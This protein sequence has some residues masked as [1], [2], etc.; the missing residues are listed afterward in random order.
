[1]SRP[2]LTTIVDNTGN[3]GRT[4]GGWKE[5][6]DKRV[7]FE[8]SGMDYVPTGADLQQFYAPK[9]MKRGQAP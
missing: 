9:C 6:R 4:N 5:R 8:I 1:M 7:T 2:A 3:N